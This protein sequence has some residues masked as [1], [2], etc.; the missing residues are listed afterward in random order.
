MSSIRIYVKI[1]EGWLYQSRETQDDFDPKRSSSRSIRSLSDSIRSLSPSKRNTSPPKSSRNKEWQK[2]YFILICINHE[3]QQDSSTFELHEYDKVGGN[4]CNLYP[5]KQLEIHEVK[6]K[7]KI[8]NFASSFW[9]NK[10]EETDFML[11][12]KEVNRESS[13]AVISIR[14]ENHQTRLEWINALQFA[15]HNSNH[16]LS[17]RKRVCATTSTTPP[18]ENTKTDTNSNTAAAADITAPPKTILQE[19]T[20]INNGLDK[21]DLPYEYIAQNIK[22]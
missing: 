7:S 5:M 22:V 3:N 2:R 9:K 8:L 4:L 1:K 17:I 13:M 18:I 16:R 21:F 19:G 15:L 20:L 11:T 14:C 10:N 12:C 6:P